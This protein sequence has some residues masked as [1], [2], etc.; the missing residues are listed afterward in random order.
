MLANVVVFGQQGGAPRAA[1]V[2]GFQQSHRP[3]KDVGQDL[4][5][6]WSF[7]Q[8]SGQHDL[9]PRGSSFVIV[10]DCL[11]FLNL[12]RPEKQIEH[13]RNHGSLDHVSRSMV[14]VFVI[15]IAVAVTAIP[16]AIPIAIA[17]AIEPHYHCGSPPLDIQAG[18]VVQKRQGQQ[19]TTIGGSLHRL[20][21]ERFEITSVRIHHA[22]EVRR[23]VAQPNHGNGLSVDGVEAIYRG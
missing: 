11:R 15:T 2:G 12:L 19:T 10:V 17:I 13:D 1:F 4:P 21:Q 18:L 6:L 7:G 23:P 8:A 20:F 22:I 14:P 5:R 16:I 9:F 3:I